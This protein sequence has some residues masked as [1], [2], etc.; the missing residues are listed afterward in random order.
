MLDD[1][2]DQRLWFLK[3]RAISKQYQLVSYQIKDYIIYIVTKISPKQILTDKLESCHQHR[4]ESDIKQ[5]L[6]TY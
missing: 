2:M 1:I 3:W 6:Y 4:G 5:L